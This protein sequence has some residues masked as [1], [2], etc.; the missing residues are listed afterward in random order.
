MGLNLVLGGIV[1][2]GLQTLFQA[3]QRAGF[4]S[5]HSFVFNRILKC[6]KDLLWRCFWVARFVLP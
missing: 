2:V 4:I 5:H 1:H 6:I 3:R